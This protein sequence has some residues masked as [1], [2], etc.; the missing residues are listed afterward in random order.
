MAGMWALHGQLHAGGPPWDVLRARSRA[1][2]R[3]IAPGRR[4]IVLT[5]FTK[6]KMR[7]TAEIAR[8]RAVMDRC[9]RE[10]HTPDEDEEA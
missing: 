1:W 5:V 9:R 3:L 8:A 10:A 2:R 6:T 7:E 4:I